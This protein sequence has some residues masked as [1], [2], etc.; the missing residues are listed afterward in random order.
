MILSADLSATILVQVKLC[1]VWLM[2]YINI[3]RLNGKKG[4]LK[5]RCMIAFNIDR[6]SV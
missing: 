5:L 6:R 2:A 4:D 3:L 1:Q